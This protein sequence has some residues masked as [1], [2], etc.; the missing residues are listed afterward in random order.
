ME[1]RRHQEH[2]WLWCAYGDSL[3]WLKQSKGIILSAV[4][5]RF[6]YR[7]C[8]SEPP[9]HLD[10]QTMSL[11]V[12]FTGVSPARH[13]VEGSANLMY[14]V[15]QGL[16]REGVCC[17][18][19]R[20]WWSEVLIGEWWGLSLLA[21]CICL[22]AFYASIW[23]SFTPFSTKCAHVSGGC[24]VG[25]G[26]CMVRRGQCCDRLTGVTLCRLVRI[27]DNGT[28]T[29]DMHMGVNISL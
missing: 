14:L 21:G 1:L 27:R 24:G 26:C 23:L 13:M 6:G 2:D 12:A 17:S 28:V 16:G 8:L 3:R 25:G 29:R 18:K 20:V 7:G 15:Q 5:L 9:K 11:I 22:V 4:V 10:V 19:L